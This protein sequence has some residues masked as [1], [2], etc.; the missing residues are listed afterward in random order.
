QTNKTLTAT[1]VAATATLQSIKV[2][3][4]ALT[5]TVVVT[6]SLAKQVAKTLSASVAGL[7]SL[8]TS[9]ISGGGAGI[10]TAFFG[11]AHPGGGTGEGSPAG[12]IGTGTPDEP[13]RYDPPTPDQS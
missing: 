7:A 9:F 10:I 8:V 13:G 2:I 11:R 6:G 12:G 3:L 1:T 4:K 5:A